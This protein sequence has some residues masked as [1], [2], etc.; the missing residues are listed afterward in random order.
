MEKE[1]IVLKDNTEIEIENGAST[2]SITMLVTNLDEFK[3][4]YG[5]M[6]EGNLEVFKILN[7]AGLV[8]TEQKNKYVT[9]AVVSTEETGY[10]VTF[11]LADVDM[12]GKRLAALEEGQEIQDGGI[13]DLADAVSTIVEGGNA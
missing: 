11:N 4:L 5:Q 7:A 1:K 2:S 10:R 8:C 12:V 3:V 9:N 13:A 6:N